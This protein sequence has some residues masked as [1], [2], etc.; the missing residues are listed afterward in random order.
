MQNASRDA[1][2]HGGPREARAY[3]RHLVHVLE[4][5]GDDCCEFYVTEWFG[6]ACFV[7]VLKVS[8][9]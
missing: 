2:A 5:G 7:G 8:G 1:Q 3:T 6:G 4:V 9:L